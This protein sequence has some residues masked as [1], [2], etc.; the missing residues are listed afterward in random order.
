[1]SDPIADRAAAVAR[2]AT[3][4][5]LIDA[6][7]ADLNTL[8]TAT[9]AGGSAWDNFAPA[10]RTL[11]ING[12]AKDMRALALEVKRIEAALVDLQP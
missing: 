1:M 12:L 4:N 8:I 7:V 6:G 9:N 11:S 2:L 10:N 3:A 5:T